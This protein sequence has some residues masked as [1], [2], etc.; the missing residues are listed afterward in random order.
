M[1]IT[2]NDIREVVFSP[3]LSYFFFN[4][5]DLRIHPARND[6]DAYSSCAIE[7]PTMEDLQLRK[8]FTWS[9]INNLKVTLSR[10][11]TEDNVRTTSSS[12]TCPT[13]DPLHTAQEGIE[14]IIATWGD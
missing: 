10:G 6:N 11:R 7:S 14:T 12:N 4:Q 8:S 13:E 1:V 2:K 9:L 3:S 5:L